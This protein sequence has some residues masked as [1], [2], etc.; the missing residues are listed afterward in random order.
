MTIGEQVVLLDDAGNQVGT[1]DKYAVHHD[2][3]PLHLAFSSYVFDGAGRFLLTRRALTKKTWPGVWTNSC[4]GH[5]LP[6]EPVADA[7]GR[8]LTD[9]LGLPGPH[10]LD[11]VLPAFR[12]RATMPDGIVENEMCPVYRVVVDTEPDPNPDEV[13]SIRWVAWTTLL[14]EISSGALD[15]SPWSV[16]QLT[17]LIPLGDPVDWP[18][19]DP[20]HLPPVA[21]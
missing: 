4:C 3:T 10:K 1:A 6:G 11:L 21:H 13:D 9:E 8:R 20:A 14:D 2:S 16:L 7:V 15:L 17:D 12:Y 19:G 18:V 5:P